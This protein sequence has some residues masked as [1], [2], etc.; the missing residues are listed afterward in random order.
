MDTTAANGPHRAPARLGWPDARELAARV[1]AASPLPPEV[2]PL[3]D[4][5]GRRLAGDL[6]AD[7]DLPHYASAAMD[8]WLV[9]GDGPWRLGAEAESG[10]FADDLPAAGAA[11]PIVTGAF[12]P[13]GATAVLRSESGEVVGGLLRSTVPGEPW[14]GQHIRPPGT[15]ATRG[16]RLIEAGAMLNPAHIAIAAATGRDELAV[17]AVPEVAL[18]LTGE[19]VVTAGIPGPGRVRDSF[20]VQFPAFLGMLGGRVIAANRV[21]DDLDDTVRTIRDADAPL[22]V[23]TGGTGTSTADHVRAA[24]HLLG[25]RVVVDGIAMRPGGPTTVA[26]L[27]GGRIVAALPGNPLAAMLG[28]LTVIEPLLAGLAANPPAGLRTVAAAAAPGRRGATTLAPY[29]WVEGRATVSAWRGAAMLRGLA[30]ASGVLVIPP[31][32]VADGVGAQS[33]ALPW[34]TDGEG[35][36]VRPEQL[37]PRICAAAEP[38][39]ES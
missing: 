36:R 10:R 21:A 33:L 8:G 23:S 2:V 14:P 19:E 20:G 35:V 9:T 25:A 24:L 30:E 28:A 7:I 6:I 29:V 4:A 5:V 3:A 12:V 31:E 26:V 13:H 32:G 34:R 15:E 11:R 17:R 16:E 27:P 37:C 1:G 38:K 22:I 18:V 39:V